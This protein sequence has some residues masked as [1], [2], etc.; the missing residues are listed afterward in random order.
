MLLPVK[1]DVFA[2]WGR[3]LDYFE[4]LAVGQT[5]RTSGVTV[6]EE[7]IIRFALEYDVQPFHVDKVAAEKTHF[8]GLIASGIHT[9]ALTF[10]L[11][12]QAH[13]FAGNSMAGIGFDEV[14]FV[15]PVHP[16][17][18]IHAAVTIVDHRSSAKHTTA[19]IVKWGIKTFNQNDV[20]VF[21]GTLI[22]LI[23]K[24]GS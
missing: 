11:C 6:T 3:N 2:K 21:R 19:G 1:R 4:D 7:A 14:R 13:L 5:F 23:N 20:L 10:R 17:D 24:R 9:L 12:N 15:R 18:T 16:G 22:N 8:G